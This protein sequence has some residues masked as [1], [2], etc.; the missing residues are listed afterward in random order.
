MSLSV[1]SARRVGSSHFG[2]HHVCTLIATMTLGII[3]FIQKKKKEKERKKV[4]VAV[5]SSLFAPVLHL[6]LY[7]TARGWA[8]ER[9]T[10]WSYST[11][12]QADPTLN[13]TTY[14]VR[15]RDA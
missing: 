4:C 8:D 10:L 14:G 9:F 7:W 12:T 5:A 2:T 3:T 11:V 6:L 13:S 1:R 15:A